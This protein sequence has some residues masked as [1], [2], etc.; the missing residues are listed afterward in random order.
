MRSFWHGT[1]S[2]RSCTTASSADMPRPERKG[3]REDMAQM[4]VVA[5]LI[6]RA[7]GKFLICRRP[8]HKARGGLW[9][10]VG[11]KVEPGETKEEALRRECMEELAI[12][13]E[14][15]GVFAHVVHEYPDTVVSLTLLRA[16][17]VRGEPQL[18]EHS[19]MRWILP[20]ETDLYEFCP[21]DGEIL[22]KIK[23]TLGKGQGDTE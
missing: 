11:G 15:E 19:D 20:S 16:R 7:D 3:E 17:I 10:F 8:A 4:E 22:T 1:A 12:G 23:E 18:L 5:A 6:V 13:T 14:P 2:M 9:E 21:A